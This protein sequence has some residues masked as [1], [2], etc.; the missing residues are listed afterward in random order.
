MRFKTPRTHDI[1]CLWARTKVLSTCDP[2]WKPP[3][4]V[5]PEGFRFE[6]HVLEDPGALCLDG[7]PAA[8]YYG[9]PVTP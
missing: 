2:S 1:V 5:G 9:R 8:F 3:P 6:L 4:P 7:S